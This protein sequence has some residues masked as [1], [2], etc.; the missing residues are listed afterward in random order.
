VVG[1]DRLGVETIGR[2]V[3]MLG[4]WGDVAQ[5][6]GDGVGRVVANMHVFAHALTYGGHRADDLHETT[7]CG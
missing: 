1:A 3:E 7:P 6:P 4:E 2:G 5:I